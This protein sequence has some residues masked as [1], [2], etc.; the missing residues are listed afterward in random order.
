VTPVAPF[1]TDAG[2]TSANEGDVT[3]TQ[4]KTDATVVLPAPPVQNTAAAEPATNSGQIVYVYGYSTPTALGFFTVNGAHTITVPL[5]GLPKGLHRLAI[6]DSNGTFLGWLSVT[7]GGG[8][9]STG[10]NVNAPLEAGGAGLLILLG[11]LSVVFVTRQRR[12]AA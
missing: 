10:V 1:A 4:T 12:T 11:I 9:A 6:I 7:A 2:L 8:L 5:G 3:G